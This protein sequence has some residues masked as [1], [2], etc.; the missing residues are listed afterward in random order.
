M[1]AC[2]DQPSKLFTVEQ[3]NA[4]LPLVSAIV[5]DLAHLAREVVDRRERLAHLMAG[6]E[7]ESGDP[8]EEELAQIEEELQKD[9]NR[10]RGF[11]EE[12]QQLGVETKGAVEGLVD[13]PAKFDGRKVCLCWKLGEPEILYWH[14]LE[15]GFAGRQ[16]LTA[17]VADDTSDQAGM[18]DEQGSDD[19]GPL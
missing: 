13:F 16:P 4:T 8:Y 6:R 17:T 14:E 10:L 7:L 11:V 12:L 3:A 15:A 1:S 19:Y 9:T 18:S 5:G 2:E